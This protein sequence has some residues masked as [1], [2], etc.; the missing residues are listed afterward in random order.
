MPIELKSVPDF[1]RYIQGSHL[2]VPKE[3]QDLAGVGWRLVTVIP[4]GNDSRMAYFQRNTSTESGG[5]R[6]PWKRKDAQY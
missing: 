5:K 6:K 2:D 3:W 4:I 1:R